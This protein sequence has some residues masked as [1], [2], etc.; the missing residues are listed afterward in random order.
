MGM[1]TKTVSI[2]LSGALLGLASWS[3]AMA[4]EQG[5]WLVRF[6]GSNVDPKSDNH[7]IVEVDG[8]AS[9]TFNFSYLLTP[10]WAVELLA[11][12]PFKHDINLI[13]GDEVGSTKHLPPTLSVQYHFLPEAAIQPYVGVGINY[14]NFFDEDTSGALAGTRLSLDDS[15]GWA[16][17][18]GVDFPLNERWFL[19]L[20]VRWIDIETSAKLDGAGIGT[21]EIDPVVYGAHLGVRF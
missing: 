10:N 18:V 8:A 7:S 17:Q 16:A 2:M 5:D 13:G 6:G 15:W 12:L 21:V 9:V 11:A 19:N 14:T 3:T 20:D 4:H 1:Q